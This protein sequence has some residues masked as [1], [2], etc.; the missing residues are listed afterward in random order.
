VSTVT[1]VFVRKNIKNIH[2]LNGSD[3]GVDLDS[4]V[5]SV[6]GARSVVHQC[7]CKFF[8]TLFSHSFKICFAEFSFYFFMD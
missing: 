5:F 1:I 7:P 4:F 8:C 3:Q 2:E 6:A